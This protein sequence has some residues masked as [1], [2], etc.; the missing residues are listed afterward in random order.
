MFSSRLIAFVAAGAALGAVAQTSLYIPGF[1]PQPVSAN[2]LGV[3]SD[4]RTTW[5]IAP[6]TASGS[7]SDNG[8]VG[9]ATLIEG[10][11][12]AQLFLSNDLE[13]ISESCTINNGLADCT[14][15][16]AIQ[17]TSTTDSVQETASPFPVQVGSQAATTP[18]QP[19]AG[20]SPSAPASTP[21]GP[22]GPATP[23]QTPSGSAPSNTPTNQPNGAGALTASS[24]VAGIVGFVVSLS[25]L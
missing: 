1:D 15:V 11:N 19:A 25:M 10:P 17:G 6:G 21:T 14:V 4:G 16:A 23:A 12:D 8:F 3:G 2:M 24:I 9:T 22:T 20:S 5:Q 7:L 13:F 18:T